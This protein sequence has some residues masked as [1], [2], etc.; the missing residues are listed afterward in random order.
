LNDEAVEDCKKHGVEINVWTV[1]DMNGLLKAETWG[2]MGIIT[3]FPDI[4]K[5]WLDREQNPD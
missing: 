5:V 4:C 3:N 2:L 1:N